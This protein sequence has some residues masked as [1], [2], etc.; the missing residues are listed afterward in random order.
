MGYTTEFSGEIEVS[1]PLNEAERAYLRRFATSR[2][3]DRERG[4]YYAEPGSDY[5][6]GDRSDVKDGNTPPEGQPGLW[7]QWVPTEDGSGIEWD[8]GEKFYNAEE[9]MAYL[10]DTFLKPGC[11]V[12]RELEEGNLP[13]LI[14]AQF[15]DFTFDHACNG[16]IEADGEKP[17]DFWL[18]EVKDNV[19]SA[20]NGRVA[21]DESSAPELVPTG[22][23]ED[24]HAEAIEAG[25]RVFI[26]GKWQT[27]EAAGAWPTGKPNPKV[28]ITTEPDST[29]NGKPIELR[30]GDALDILADKWRKEDEINGGDLVELVGGL[31]KET[32]RPLEFTL[33]TKRNMREYAALHA[34]QDR[35]P[36]AVAV[37]LNGAEQ[38]S[39]DDGD[40]FDQGEDDPLTDDD[41]EPMVLAV[42]SVRGWL[43]ALNRAPIHV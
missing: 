1:P 15:A 3:M 43:D 32:G 11:T 13:D 28:E 40:Y 19:V 18:L 29:M 4:P 26:D 22:E 39:G 6:Q 20:R 23:Y 12:E 9:W 14:A 7:C 24:R 17:D 21:Y 36:K 41:G 38:Y 8:Q 5:G 30:D 42:W 16:Q 35:P 27:V 10:I 31:L 34:D 37:S 33:A 2:R 25:D